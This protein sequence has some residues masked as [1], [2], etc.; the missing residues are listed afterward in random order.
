MILY[1]NIG[2]TKLPANVKDGRMIRAL[3]DNKDNYY[4]ISKNSNEQ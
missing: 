1:K 4:V 3:K 2:R